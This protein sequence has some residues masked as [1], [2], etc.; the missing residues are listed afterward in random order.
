VISYISSASKTSPQFADFAPHEIEGELQTMRFMQGIFLLCLCLLIAFGACRRNNPTLVDKNEAPETQLWYSPPDSVDYEYL[1]HLYWRGE[2]NDGTATSFIWTI[3]DSILAGELGWNP[4][5]RLRDFREGRMTTRTDTVISFSAYKKIEGVGVKKNRQAFYIA[6]IDDN[7]VIDESPAVVEFI[8]TI[9]ELPRLVFTTHI[10]DVSRPYTNYD[11]PKD[12]VGVLQP[13]GV[14]YHG[15]TVNGL[16]RG[17][18]FY[19]FTTGVEIDGQNEWTENLAD[20]LREFPNSGADLIPSGIFRLAAMCVDDAQA[21]SPVDAGNYRTGVCQIVVN[22]DP[23]TVIHGVTNSYTIDDVVYEEDVEFEDG[24]PDTVPFSSWTRILYTGE[25]DARDGKIA[26]NEFNPDT[27]IGFR[28]GYYKTSSR[29]RGAD[30]FSLWQPREGMHDTD[31]HSSTDSNTFHI[32]SLEYDLTVHAID[33]LGR[34]DGTPPSVHIIGNYD[35]ILDSLVVED[36]LGN[37]ID[38]SIV[39]TV[40]WNFWRGEGWPYVCQCDTVD[41]PQEACSPASCAGRTYPRNRGTYDYYKQFTIHI[42]AWGHDHPKD[43]SGSGIKEWRYYVKNSQG[44][45][46]NFSKGLAGWFPYEVDGEKQ[47]NHVDDVFRW[48]VLY[49]GL[50]SPNPDPLGD[51]VFANL[52]WFLDQDMTFFFLGRDSGQGDP[53]FSQ[54]IFINGKESVIN[55]FPATEF[56]RWTKER[57]F[58]FRITLVR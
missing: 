37:R 29:V 56:G 11:V 42:K 17:Y 1:V 51:T 55:V 33:E 54:S 6:A 44:E 36:H 24:I 57:V 43:P 52:P 21:E 25:D 48:R 31:P 28:V 30:E 22:Y 39:D 13:F 27:C 53:E 12:T 23:D 35:P 32:G 40:E 2:D 34:P 26:C 49:P 45:F 9:G 41:L 47:L 46:I 3:R 4:A 5:S 7:G 20:T 19:P 18:Y 50:L 10:A 16:V 14:S 8:A 15:L 38:L 58:A